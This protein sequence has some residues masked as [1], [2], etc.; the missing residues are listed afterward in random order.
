MQQFPVFQ[1][2]NFAFQHDLVPVDGNIHLGYRIHVFAD[3]IVYFTDVVLHLNRKD[4]R[5]PFADDLDIGFAQRKPHKPD[6]HI[7]NGFRFDDFAVGCADRLDR[8][9]NI[10]NGHASDGHGNFVFC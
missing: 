2:G 1:T 4:F 7:G 9:R 10:G 3:R 8:E 5:G 6:L